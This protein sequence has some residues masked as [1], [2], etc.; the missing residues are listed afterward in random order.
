MSRS[1]VAAVAAIGAFPAANHEEPEDAAQDGPGRGMADAEA[2]AAERMVSFADDE[3]KV[4]EFDSNIQQVK[5]QEF[6]VL[7]YGLFFADR[8]VIF[9]IRSS[10]IGEQIQLTAGA[11][12]LGAHV[13]TS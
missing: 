7:Y 8:V 6:D 9:R 2:T 12:R 13:S 11:E 5:P 1:A 4:C 10:E 3:W